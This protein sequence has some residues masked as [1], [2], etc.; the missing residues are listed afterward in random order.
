MNLLVRTAR[1]LRRLVTADFGFTVGIALVGVALEVIGRQTAQGGYDL[2]D[3]LALFTVIVMAIA[4]VFRH[5]RSPLK[6]VASIAAAGR[7]AGTWLRRSTFEIGLDLRGAPR[8]RRGSPP[9]VVWLAAVLATWAIAAALLAPVCPHGLR[10]AAAGVFYLGYL[11]ILSG[12]WL[13][14]MALGLLA[15][16]L[17]FALIHDRCIGSFIGPGPRPRKRE[18]AALASY[19]GTLA[20]VGTILPVAF[21]LAWC[22]LILAAYLLVC[23]LPTRGDVRFLWRPYGTI[24]VRSLPWGAWVTWEF[25]LITLAI[26]ALV[27]TALGDRI[28]GTG[29]GP[30]AMPVTALL[31]LILA[32]LAP[33]ALTALLIHITL[34]RWRDPARPARPLAH[35]A[36][37]IAG[38]RIALRR[39]FYRQGWAVRFG[40]AVPGGNDVEVILVEAKLPTTNDEPRWPLPV[41]L[42]ELQS[43]AGLWERLRRR[44]EIQA[45]RRVIGGLERLFKLAA[46]RPSRGGSGYWV[47]PHLWFIAGLMRDGDDEPDLADNTILSRTAGPPYHRVLP[48][49]ARHHMYRMMRALQ[50][51][52]IFVEDG[53]G[54]RRLRKV[55]RVL[56]EVYDI[57]AGRRPAEEVDFR[58]LPGT[59]VLIHDF[60]FD[61]PF[62]SEVYPEPKYDY[63]GRARILHVFRD[64]G[65]QEEPLESPFDYSHTP[66]PAGAY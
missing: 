7:R 36:G 12:V 46:G 14:L 20:I 10:P 9:I 44:A 33:G 25:L 2:H 19:F 34:G 60:Q 54:F 57:H 45:R 22:G 1:D 16:F 13:G 63:L 35:V 49:A 8:V 23:W 58:G 39:L 31:G 5:R 17:P 64:R 37:A 27:L 4:I 18:Y 3:L 47:A 50:V 61:E 53:V 30:E 52:L 65:E 43:D 40:P 42:S 32:W 11:A 48:R 59:R 29:L 41:T 26:F 55:L 56:F 21:A 15:A 6:W 28:A 51:D 66:A 62:R 38:R 24:R